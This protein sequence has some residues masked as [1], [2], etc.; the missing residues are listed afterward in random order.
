[1][2]MGGCGFYLKGFAQPSQFLNG[3]Y[4]A[5]GD[6]LEHLSGMLL[7]EL[8][9]GGVKMAS[10]A[11]SALYQVEITEEKTA[12]RVL[13]VDANGKALDQE[14]YLRVAFRLTVPKKSGKVREEHD[15]ELVRQLSFSGD[16]ELGRRNEAE[17]IREDLRFDM[18]VQ[19]IRR[20]EARMKHFTQDQK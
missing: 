16:D 9:L 7:Q 2:V 20:L 14:I 6:D 10:R 13:S 12:T 4:I 1:M 15:L 19:I 8:Q 18:V 17:L 11:K 3:G 5:G